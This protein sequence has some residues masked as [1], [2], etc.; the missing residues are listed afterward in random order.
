[1]AISFKTGDLE[2]IMA[3]AQGVGVYLLVEAVDRETWHLAL[4]TNPN[5]TVRAQWSFC[6]SLPLLTELA[7]RATLSILQTFGDE[8]KIEQFTR[9]LLGLGE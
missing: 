1:M 7:Y 3:A 5:L 4:R 2:R 8:R 6:P 9:A